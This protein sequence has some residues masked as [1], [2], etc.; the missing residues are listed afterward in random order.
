MTKIEQIKDPKFLKKLNI[1]ECEDL[2]KSMRE[3]I[4][5]K[6]S[7]N[8]GHL[9]SNLGIVD[10]TIA[11]LKVFDAEKDIILFDVGHECYPYKILT[12]RSEQFDTLRKFNGLSGF[13]SLNESKYDRYEAGHSSTSIGSGLG[14]AIARDLNKENHHVITVIGDGSISN[15]LAYEAINHLGD[16]KTKQIIIFNKFHCIF[17]ICC[18]SYS[19]IKLSHISCS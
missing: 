2:A 1:N 3:F 4:L 14:F 6:V 12:G 8:G 18:S 17:S 9:S 16:L 5:D 13:Q 11:M 7:K 15:G 19:K 10:L